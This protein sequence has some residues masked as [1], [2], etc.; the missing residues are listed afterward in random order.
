MYKNG[1]KGIVIYE[2]HIHVYIQN[3]KVASVLKLEASISK[4]S[5]LYFKCWRDGNNNY[6]HSGLTASF[7][8]RFKNK[9]GRIDWTFISGAT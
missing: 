9:F 7:E 6:K 3:S 1:Q 5:R 4:K 8:K 2:K